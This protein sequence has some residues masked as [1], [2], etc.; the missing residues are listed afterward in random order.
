[1]HGIVNG[2][3]VGGV[4]G[5]GVRGR[6]WLLA[7][8]LLTTGVVAEDSFPVAVPAAPAAVAV[9]VEGPSRDRLRTMVEWLASP[10]REGRGPGTGGIDRAAIWVAGE[11]AEIGLETRVVADEPFQKFPI[12][13]DAKPGPDERNHVELVG[14]PGPDGQPRVVPLALNTDFTPLA[15]GGS[16]AFDLPLVF[17]GYGISAPAEKYDDY[18]PLPPA[19][20]GAAPAAVPAGFAKG[21][22]V[23]VLRQE[24]QKDDPHSVFN[25]NQASQYAALTRKIA[26]ASEHEVG[27]V[28]FCNDAS[29]SDDAMMRFNRAGNGSDGRTIPILQIKRQPVDTILTAVRGTGLAAAEKAIDESLTPQSGLLDGWRIRGEIL[30]ERRETQARNVLAVLEGTGAEGIAPTET[31]VV[32]AHYDH[33]GFGGSESAAPGVEAIH[34]GADDN[35]SGTA[36][37]IEVAR[38][39]A[40]GGRLPR[41]V[42][43]VAFSGEERGLL[44]S[45]HYAANPV[46][47]LADTVAM[48]NLDMVGRMEGDKLI[49]HGTG[50]GSGLDALVDRLT[51]AHGFSVTK[52]PGGFGPSDHASFYAKKIPVLHV[53]SGTHGDYHRPTDTAEKINYDGMVRIAR[54]VTDAVRELAT[55]AE[56]PAYI[57]VASRTFAR[58]GD[59]P[60]FGSIPDFGR[61]AKGYALSGVA[62]DSPAAKGGLQGGDLVV[63]IGDSAVTGLDDFDSALR[64]YKGGDT[65][66]VVVERDGAEVSLPVTLGDPR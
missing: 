55:G 5:H 50:T 49:I 32:G 7:G 29:A 34:H 35:A 21:A 56:R 16:G 23:I 24:P 27:A 66:T 14:P 1:M 10:Q 40:A 62:K 39:L 47:A 63:R 57:E 13:L 53:F 15:A 36:L 44:G 59:R 42:L 37:L 2:R 38:Q 58:G 45:A 20:D 64:K 25:G 11:L 61:T 48:V 12:T 65:V 4:V 31:V 17:A 52:D 22:A 60:Y 18:A 51:A 28:V 6:A 19:A 3:M 54:M 30:V 33:L 8:A 41:R 43:F 46:I 26:N 9:P